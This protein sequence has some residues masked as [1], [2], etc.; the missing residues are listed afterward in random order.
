MASAFDQPLQQL[1]NILRIAEASTPQ[2]VLSNLGTKNLSEA[3]SSCL[4]V[5]VSCD[6]APK[7]APLAPLRM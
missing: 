6:M 7:G 5:E 1:G 3:E 4:D 2:N